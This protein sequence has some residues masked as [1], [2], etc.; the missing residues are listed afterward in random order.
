MESTKISIFCPATIANLSCGFDVLGMALEGIGDRMNVSLTQEKGVQITRITGGDLPMEAE[1]NVAGVAAL[2]LLDAAHYQGGVAIEIEKNILP[3]S[4]I[5]SSAA[6][7]AGAVWAIN[8]LLGDPFTP[9]QLVGF[10][11][12][13][14]AL[15]SGSPHA[16]NVAPALY[17][18][19]TLIRSYD[20]L[21]I[22]KVHCPPL[23]HA[24]L[25]HP[26]IELKTSDS[27]SILKRT[28]SLEKGIRQ[29]GNVGGLITGL[30]TEDYGLISRSLEDRIIEPLRSL[31]IPGFDDLRQAA[32]KAGALGFGISGSGPSVFAL[33]TGP[34]V[35]LNT[36]KSLINCYQSLGIPFKTYTSAINHRGVR[37]W[38]YQTDS[39]K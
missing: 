12:L 10:A 2:A 34:E 31:L 29:W 32:L 22:A 38:N 37:L 6:S 5:G 16:D 15:A 30:F 24:A 36:E 17:G 28:I 7:A 23:L 21:D 9:L 1:K 11:S 14:E 3:G 8:K 4:G 20:P 33:T 18:G 27:R 13:G 35:A 19:I 25:L 39:V 26:Q